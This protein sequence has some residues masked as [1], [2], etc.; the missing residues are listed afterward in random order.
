MTRVGTRKGSIVDLNVK[1]PS[2][3]PSRG[4]VRALYGGTRSPGK[5]NCRPCMNVPRL[6]GNFTT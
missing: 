6:H 4:A 1:D 5:R 2:V 3:P